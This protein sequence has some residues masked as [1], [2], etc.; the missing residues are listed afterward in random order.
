MSHPIAPQA[1]FFLAACLLWAPLVGFATNLPDFTEVVELSGKAVVNITTTSSNQEAKQLV[2]DDLRLEIEKT[3]LMNVLREVFGDKLEETLSG[4][5]PGVGSGTIV[6]SDG[7][8]VTNYHV[9]NGA[10]EI[11]VRLKDRRG[12][13]AKV[14]GVDLGTDLALIKIDA[15]DL[16][17]LEL[18]K[19]AIPKV[20]QWVIAIG[21]PFGF[22]NTVT[23]GVV[24]ALGRNLGEERYVP[25]IQTDVAINPG[26]SGGPLIDAEGHVVGINSQIVSESGNF[27][28]L[29][30][31]VPASV[32]KSVVSQIKEKGF[33]TRGWIGLAFQDLTRE[34]AESFGM[35]KVKGALIAK[36]MPGSPAAKAGIEQGDIIVEFNGEDVIFASDLPPKVGL[37][38]IDSFVNVTILRNQKTLPFKVKIESVPQIRSQVLTF[39]PISADQTHYG[40]RVR[41]MEGAELTQLS[42]VKGVVVDHVD[43][44]I[45][46]RAGIREKDVIVSIDKKL[47]TN[48]KAFYSV[49]SSLPRNQN[50]SLL[51]AR[52][53]EVERYVAVKLSD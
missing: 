48:A 20:G 49:L 40:I 2:S 1:R 8:I 31:S 29:S 43:S 3:P 17:Y 34:L 51:V 42:G 22:E 53:G 7:Y 44:K 18:E 47:V 15:K 38:P 25:F 4:Q 12:Y 11:F 46:I 37:I 52:S 21:S 19:D 26:N 41:D 35:Q 30:F 39:N 10:D 23:V 14:I 24:S 33:V 27:A 6:S 13:L 32:V 50:I 45:W 28:G 5:G 36:V 9:I 16:P